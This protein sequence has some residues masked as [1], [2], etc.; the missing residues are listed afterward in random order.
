LVEAHEGRPLRLYVYNADYD[1]T[2]EVIIVPNRE[3]GGEGLLGCGVGFG[4]LHRIPRPQDRPPVHEAEEGED[5]QTIRGTAAAGLLPQTSS[6]ATR[7]PPPAKSN[8]GSQRN[9]SG[10]TGNS[11][12]RIEEEEED[13]EGEEGD[14]SH[15]SGVTISMRRDDDEDDD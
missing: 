6:A 11:Q 9:G 1:H 14:D 5:H 8:L 2:R 3:W 13:E 15:T 7:G 10:G 12:P 4:L